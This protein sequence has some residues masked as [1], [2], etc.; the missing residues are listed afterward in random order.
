MILLKGAT[1]LEYL[2]S[3][4]YGYQLWQVKQ[5]SARGFWKMFAFFLFPVLFWGGIKTAGWRLKG[6][7]ATLRGQC[8][9]SVHRQRHEAA[10]QSLCHLSVSTLGVAVQTYSGSLTKSGFYP[11]QAKAGLIK[12]PLTACCLSLSLIPLISL[13]RSVPSF[14]AFL[15]Q[16]SSTPPPL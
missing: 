7:F 10:T 12:I 15:L 6:H 8:W 5:K 11:L 13:L 16:P 9:S 4:V 14:I 1:F 2:T 3:T